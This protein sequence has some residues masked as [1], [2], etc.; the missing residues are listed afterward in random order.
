MSV[1]WRINL[2]LTKFRYFRISEKIA[3]INTR[4]KKKARKLNTGHLTPDENKTEISN[5]LSNVPAGKW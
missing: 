5:V 2:I 3:K 4:E 1:A